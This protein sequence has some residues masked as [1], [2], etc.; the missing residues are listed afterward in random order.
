MKVTKTVKEPK[1]TTFGEIPVNSV[2]QFNDA[3]YKKCQNIIKDGTRPKNTT[4]T[5]AF[6]VFLFPL[7]V[8]RDL[9]RWSIGETGEGYF[10]ANHWEVFLVTIEEVKFH[11]TTE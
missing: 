10:F 8:E 9:G 11:L 5:E 1:K 2:F 7:D 3:V 4:F 6:A